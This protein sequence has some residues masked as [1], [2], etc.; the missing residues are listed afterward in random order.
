MKIYHHD[1]AAANLTKERRL[2][3]FLLSSIH[4]HNVITFFLGTTLLV[5]IRATAYLV[6]RFTRINFSTFRFRKRKENK[7]LEQEP[8]YLFLPFIH[9]WAESETWSEY[10]TKFWEKINSASHTCNIP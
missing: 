6:M 8:K 4:L 3:F 10:P 9:S 2:P 1:D 7:S 5:R